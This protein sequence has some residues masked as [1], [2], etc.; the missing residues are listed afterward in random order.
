MMSIRE[1]SLRMGLFTNEE[2]EDGIWNERMIGALKNTPGFKS[3]SAW[4]M[5]THK[6]KWS[7]QHKSFQGLPHY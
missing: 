4:E 3:Q 6:K 5:I 2:D 1:W 7:L